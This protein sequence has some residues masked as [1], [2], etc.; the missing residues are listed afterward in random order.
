MSIKSKAVIPKIGVFK[1]E[2]D[3]ICAYK[4]VPTGLQ[5]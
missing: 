2:F 4:Q 3:D 5:I 1:L